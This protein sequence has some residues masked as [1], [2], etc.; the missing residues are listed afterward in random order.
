MQV[1]SQTQ[2]VALIATIIIAMLLVVI[3]ALARNLMQ[4]QSVTV[5]VAVAPTATT[6]PTPTTPL[7]PTPVA[8]TTST[9]VLTKTP[10]PT[11]T[12]LP[13]FT[14]TALPI[15]SWSETSKLTSLEYLN[16]VII[17]RE[18]S[19]EGIDQVI[20]GRDRVLMMVIGKIHAGIDLEKLPV[21]KIEIKGKSI[22]LVIPRAKILAVELLPEESR[23]YEADHTWIYSNYE[24]LEKEALEEART[25]LQENNQHNQ[26]MLQMAET[27]ARLQ[28]TELLRNLGYEQV[29]I[30]FE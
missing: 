20:P 28:L 23:I 3:A 26:K 14:P 16:T 22:K 21:R 2:R 25:K 30:E 12:P 29:T 4:A 8:T 15:P 11:A 24:G 5:P 6:L 9:P 19:K 18:R 10:L 1:S 7:T 13:T 27:L 17:E